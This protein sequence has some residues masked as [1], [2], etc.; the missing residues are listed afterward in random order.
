MAER[1]AL[2]RSLLGG[3]VVLAI[4]D[5]QADPP[6]PSPVESACLSP[7]AVGR[8]RSEFAAG[9]T[10]AR[11][12]MTQLGL[13]PRPVLAGKDRAPVWPDGLAGSISHTFDCAMAVVAR[14]EEVRAIG[15]DVEQGTPLEDNLFGAI[16]SESELAWLHK[17]PDP[18]L[19]AKL[20]FSAKE[21]AYKCQYP[22]SGRLF[23]FDGMELEID[24]DTG[25]FRAMFTENQPPFERGDVI[26]GRFAIGADI[27]VTAAELRPG[28][29]L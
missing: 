15:I 1:L 25:A 6:E 21:A 12:A 23:G 10:A 7:R 16:C 20:V 26:P 11:E 5:P 22:L 8:R 17:Q 18:A 14:L 4:A 29:A 13:E 9:R 24:H 28:V 19:M 2:G 27:I 3:G